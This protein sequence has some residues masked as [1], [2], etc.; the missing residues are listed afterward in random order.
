M[1][2]NQPQRQ[3]TII[4]IKVAA[5]V[6]HLLQTTLKTVKAQRDVAVDAWDFLSMEDSDMVHWEHM[7]CQVIVTDILLL[8]A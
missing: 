8:E 2:K 5:G 1:R 6:S 7:A 4:K 3:R